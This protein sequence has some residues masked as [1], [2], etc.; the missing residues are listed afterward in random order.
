M[1]KA[2]LAALAV[3]FAHAA[4]AS[5]ATQTFLTSANFPLVKPLPTIPTA[6]P[7]NGLALATGSTQAFS[8]R[9]GK[10]VVGANLTTPQSIRDTFYMNYL[11]GNVWAGTGCPQDTGQGCGNSPF[12]AVARHYEIGDPNDIHVMRNNGLALRAICSAGHTNCTSGNIYGA[13][14]RVPYEFRP[15]MTIKV[16][17][18]SPSAPHSWAPIWLF[19]GSEISPG[20]GGNPWT[21]FGT[22]TSL[23]QE[24]VGG[25]EFEIDMND[26][27]PRWNVDPAIV[28]GYQIDFGTPDIYGV[29]WNTA[30]HEIWDANRNGFVFYPNAGPFFERVPNRLSE[31]FHNLVMS[32]NGANNTIYE[33]IDGKLVVQAYME[34]AQAPTYYDGFSHTTKV[35]AM[36]LIIGNQA[37]PNWLVNGATIQENDGIYD[38]WTMTVQEITAWH[39]LIANPTNH[40]P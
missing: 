1:I 3:M 26:N 4:C 17:Y 2:G 11:V 23:I 16:R 6:V 36:H 7:G 30:P 33:F 35:Q 24:P 10:N 12:Y 21:N 22:S 9:M 19:S 31:D 37:V 27:Y 15:G 18:K 29:Q 28:A 38:G 20:P 40:M 34:Y 5:D 8:L 14:I 32:W 25:Q 13:M 39:G